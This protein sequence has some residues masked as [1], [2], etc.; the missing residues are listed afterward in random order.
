[1]EPYELDKGEE[2]ET[3][4][5]TYVE[6]LQQF[7][8]TNKITETNRKVAVLLTVIRSKAY[9]LLQNLFTPAKPADKDFA[10]IVQVIQDHLSP[11]PLTIA[12]RFKFH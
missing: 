7:F 6:R 10:E 1:M 11:K 2:W 9:G 4:G 5:E 8:I 3:Q 12:K